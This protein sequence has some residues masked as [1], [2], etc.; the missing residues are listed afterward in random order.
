MTNRNKIIIVLVV[1]AMGGFIIYNSKDN[2]SKPKIE[3]TSINQVTKEVAFKMSYKDL[4][5]A[6]TVKL[7]GIRQQVLG[8]Y[9]FQAITQGQNIV[10]SI[11]DKTNKVLKTKTV[12][13]A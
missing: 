12:S 3:V 9:T 6:T 13:F 5:F 1:L 4:K 2:N 10:L 11:K 8:D 7:G